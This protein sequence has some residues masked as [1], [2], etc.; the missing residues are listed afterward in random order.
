MR[1]STASSAETQG[2]KNIRLEALKSFFQ[3]T[4]LLA[5]AGVKLKKEVVAASGIIAVAHMSAKNGKHA[6]KA[7]RKS[8]KSEENELSMLVEMIRHDISEI[9]T[10][11]ATK[12]SKK[13]KQPLSTTNEYLAYYLVSK[14]HTVIGMLQYNQAS[15]Q[16]GEA[17]KIISELVSELLELVESKFYVESLQE[18]IGELLSV[19]TFFFYLNYLVKF[20]WLATLTKTFAAILNQTQQNGKEN[21]KTVYLCNAKTKE[22]IA[23]F[24]IL[25][26]KMIRKL[27]DDSFAVEER[28]SWW[29]NRGSELLQSISDAVYGKMIAGTSLAQLIELIALLSKLHTPQVATYVPDSKL[30]ALIKVV[31][32]AVDAGTFAKIITHS[33]YLQPLRALLQIYI[34][35]DTAIELARRIVDVYRDMNYSRIRPLS[36]ASDFLCVMPKILSYILIILKD[37]IKQEEFLL[38]YFKLS[39]DFYNSVKK[40]LEEKFNEAKEIAKSG[41]KVVFNNPLFYRCQIA[42]FLPLMLQKE[43]QR[44]HNNRFPKTAKVIIQYFETLTI[45]IPLLNQFKSLCNYLT[46]TSVRDASYL[47]RDYASDI[48]NLIKR[49]GTEVAE[50]KSLAQAFSP[51]EKEWFAKNLFSW[52]E[53]ITDLQYYYCLEDDHIDIQIHYPH[54]FLGIVDTIVGFK[55]ILEKPMKDNDLVLRV[56]R[57]FEPIL[58]KITPTSNRDITLNETWVNCIR[59]IHEFAVSLFDEQPLKLA[60]DKLNANPHIVKILSDSLKLPTNERANGEM[61]DEEQEK[62][63][64]AKNAELVENFLKDINIEPFNF[65]FEHIK[66]YL[67]EDSHRQ[68]ISLNFFLNFLRTIS[69]KYPERKVI[70]LIFSNYIAGYFLRLKE[71]FTQEG[72]AHIWFKSGITVKMLIL[73]NF[74]SHLKFKSHKLM[75]DFKIADILIDMVVSLIENVVEEY[76][77]SS[78]LEIPLSIHSSL[79]DLLCVAREAILSDEVRKSIQEQVYVPFIN[80]KYRIVRSIIRLIKKSEFHNVYFLKEFY[81]IIIHTIHSF[82]KSNRK[83]YIEHLVVKDIFDKESHHMLGDNK[84]NS[85]KNLAD[86]VAARTAERLLQQRQQQQQVPSN[87]ILIVEEQ[88]EEEKRAEVVNGE[89]KMVIEEED[90]KSQSSPEGASTR[91]NR[92]KP[93]GENESDLQEFLKMLAPEVQKEVIGVLEEQVMSHQTAAEENNAERPNNIEIEAQGNTTTST[94][95][96]TQPNGQTSGLPNDF[97]KN[98]PKD[99]VAAVLN[100]MCQTGV[101]ERYTAIGMDLNKFLE[102]MDAEERE[103]VL[104]NSSDALVKVLNQNLRK[105]FEKAKNK[106]YEKNE[107]PFL[108]SLLAEPLF[109]DAKFLEALLYIIFYTGDSLIKSKYSLTVVKVFLKSEAIYKRFREI[110]LCLLADSSSFFDLLFMSRPYQERSQSILN[111]S[112]IEEFTLAEST[113]LESFFSKF[114]E[115][116]CEFLVA[117]VP[118]F[119]HTKDLVHNSPLIKQIIQKVSNSK[120]ESSVL[121]RWMVRVKHRT[122]LYLKVMEQAIIKTI[123]FVG[124]LTGMLSKLGHNPVLKAKLKKELEFCFLSLFNIALSSDSVQVHFIFQGAFIA[125]QDKEA[126]L[127]AEGVINQLMYDLIHQ[128]AS[129]IKEFPILPHQ[130]SMFQQEYVYLLSVV[131]TFQDVVDYLF[132]LID[133]STRKGKRSL[134]QSSEQKHKAVV[135]N[136]LQLDDLH[137]ILNLIKDNPHYFDVLPDLVNV[138]FQLYFMKNITIGDRQVETLKR[139]TTNKSGYQHDE[140]EIKDDEGDDLTPN[141]DQQDSDSMNIESM[142]KIR[143]PS[144]SVE[145]I[146]KLLLELIQ[147]YQ[148]H[149]EFVRIFVMRIQNHPKTRDIIKSALNFENRR[150]YLR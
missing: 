43:Y 12:G 10:T 5:E 54:Y 42:I 135:E 34:N 48:S 47:I 79:I 140:F 23:S 29:K 31:F 121:R 68:V 107:E 103:E 102:E 60:A 104:L 33:D 21:G 115:E 70:F 28:N 69:N 64:K 11:K 39:Q 6:K 86:L 94:N 63:T 93:A 111:R 53:I 32:E 84:N 46:T 44:E 88:K 71:A 90:N 147:K 67:E 83:T 51:K 123:T 66:R 141:A 124:D 106:K 20:D 72:K 145:K 81:N 117:D 125:I 3:N 14:L 15:V 139:L 118:N 143:E 80:A 22:N 19:L 17:K 116:M 144:R 114:D 1:L 119:V 9:K 59:W 134:V 2:A 92:A 137:F 76:E 136:F 62:A 8:G 26:S 142:S 95:H 91:N 77:N 41:S 131:R 132:Y 85:Y 24:M 96:S 38:S 109:N 146:S 122:P 120:E 52:F 37:P 61:I 113:I 149:P 16:S 49:L 98:L 133:Y 89:E 128:L 100:R 138:P 130:T 7:S 110:A 105:Q 13:A 25:L 148:N 58:I 127:L 30:V 126:M 74:T 65:I 108:L 97:L 75:E 45:Q 40:Q 55:D 87:A 129:S 150:A 101:L 35:N 4:Q 82:L 36:K 78:G 57:K 99:Q 73:M 112:S 27:K 50:N 18:F 56:F